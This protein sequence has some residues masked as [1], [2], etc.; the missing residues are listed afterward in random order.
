MINLDSCL[1]IPEFYDRSNPQFFYKHPDLQWVQTNGSQAAKVPGVLSYSSWNM[2]VGRMQ[3]HF[4]NGTYQTIGKVWAGLLYYYKPGDVA[5]QVTTGD[6]EVLTCN[7]NPS[8]NVCGKL[9]N[10]CERISIYFFHFQVL[11][12]NLE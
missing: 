11:Y 4:G 9:K 1:G 5:E 3:L 6:F 2:P 8:T 10:T 12:L 7:P